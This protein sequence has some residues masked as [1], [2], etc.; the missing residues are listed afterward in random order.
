MNVGSGSVSEESEL[1]L[2]PL[3]VTVKTA[4]KLVGVGNT[5]MWGLIAAGQVDTIKIGKRRLVIFTS[6]KAL[7]QRAKG[8]T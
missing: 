1:R 3:T 8:R 5:T 7:L 6:L 2:E 4:C